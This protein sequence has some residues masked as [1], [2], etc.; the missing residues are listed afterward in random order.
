MDINKVFPAKRCAVCGKERLRASF[1]D[2]V[3]KKDGEIY[4]GWSC[5]R[6]ATASKK[7]K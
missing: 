6:K 3:H 1:T 7:E 4:C 5:F 2:Y